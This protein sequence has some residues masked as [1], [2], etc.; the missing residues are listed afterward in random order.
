MKKALFWKASGWLATKVAC[1]ALTGKASDAVQH[2]HVRDSLHCRLNGSNNVD[3]VV[4]V[5][6]GE[7][8]RAWPGNS[9]TLGAALA[10]R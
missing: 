2:D 7:S 9:M 8:L 1:L 5:I 10:K 6:F 3:A 4:F